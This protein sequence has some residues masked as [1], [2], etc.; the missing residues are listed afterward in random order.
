MVSPWLAVASPWFPVVPPWFPV[1]PPWPSVVPC[2]PLS[3]GLMSV[4]PVAG[5]LDVAAEGAG[6]GGVAGLELPD[7]GG[8]VKTL[9]LAA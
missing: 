5:K 7:V 3:V 4:L 6:E 1:V 2:E 9:G 8:D